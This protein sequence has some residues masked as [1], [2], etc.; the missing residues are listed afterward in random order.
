MPIRIED[1]RQTPA[2]AVEQNTIHQALAGVQPQLETAVAN[3]EKIAEKLDSKFN[4]PFAGTAI[5]DLIRR[6]DIAGAIVSRAVDEEADEKKRSVLINQL[7]PVYAPLIG[8]GPLVDR[9]G[10]NIAFRKSPAGERAKAAMAQYRKAQETVAVLRD[11]AY[12][13]S[14]RQK[15]R[16]LIKDNY[17]LLEYAR[18][19]QGQMDYLQTTQSGAAV[20]NELPLVLWRYY[21][22][23]RWLI[24]PF[25]YDLPPA[26]FP[27]A[28][29][30]MRID[31]PTAELAKRMIDDSIATE[32][33]G[34]HGK[35]VIDAQSPGGAGGGY[36]ECDLELAQLAS[37]VKTKTHLTLIYDDKK[38]LITRR[39]DDRI[40]DVA[41]YC[42]WYSPEHYVPA[43]DF[44][45]GSVGYHIASFTMTTLHNLPGNWCE[46]LMRD[47]MDATLGPCAEPYLAAFPNPDEFFPLLLTGKL[48]LAEVYWKTA[49]MTSWM[50][51][52]IGDP[53]YTPFK[54]DP[55]LSVSDLPAHL[56]RAITQAPQASGR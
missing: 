20:D 17:G 32:K 15:L 23:T 21:P 54:N 2:I 33:T 25:R 36:A 37:L 4:P 45:P 55:A 48:P 14:A 22:R 10:A 56:R 52:M 1:R 51:S 11:R 49:P 9:M 50:I 7:I 28:F 19:L 26:H 31:A 8:I 13:P 12:D 40:K 41:V 6:A 27:P 30:V 44:V 16:E 5:E 47:G 34:L 39:A 3:L 38:A 46:G 43:F 29:M 53:L 35:L 24:N 42:G 18:L